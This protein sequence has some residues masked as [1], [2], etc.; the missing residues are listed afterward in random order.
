MRDDAEVTRY[1]ILRLG[2]DSLARRRHSVILTSGVCLPQDLTAVVRRYLTFWHPVSEK[3]FAIAIKWRALYDP[4]F[5]MVY[6]LLTELARDQ[7]GW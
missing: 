6:F 3:G 7:V 2:H 4:N 1:Q 5:F